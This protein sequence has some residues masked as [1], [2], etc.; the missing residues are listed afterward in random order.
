MQATYA[1]YAAQD[2]ALYPY[3][4]AGLSVHPGNHHHHLA[5]AAASHRYIHFL[6]AAI[7]VYIICCGIIFDSDLNDLLNYIPCKTVF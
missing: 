7:V 2:P 5:G 3:A 4:A 1:A 6:P